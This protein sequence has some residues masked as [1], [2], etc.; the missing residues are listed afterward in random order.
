[1]TARRSFLPGL[2]VVRSL[3]AGLVMTALVGGI[4]LAG[5]AEA[6][7]YGRPVG[8]VQ[9]LTANSAKRT[10]TISGWAYEP[11]AT[12]A[13]V[14]ITVTVDRRP[15][16]TATTGYYR[17]DVAAA[18]HIAGTHAGFSIALTNLSYARHVVCTYANIRAGTK[19]L[20]RKLGVCRAV[21]IVRPLTKNQLI[22]AYAKKFVGHYRYAT[23]GNTPRKGFD[24]S[25]LTQYIYAH[26][27]I[28]LAHYAPDQ[29]RALR[30]TKHPQAGDLCSLSLVG[31]STTLGCTRATG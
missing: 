16:K 25:G 23:G 12:T 17:P 2:S 7:T 5:S 6:A 20:T 4:A 11:A 10:A 28:N 19:T 8:T 13:R 21:T 24:C 18:Q 31:A 29:A 27:G 15:A 14:T 22:A 26:Y 3:F 30:H 1:M 9:K